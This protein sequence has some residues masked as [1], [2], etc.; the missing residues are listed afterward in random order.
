[1]IRVYV[2]IYT[3]KESCN[4]Y[5]T[6]SAERRKR[7]IRR[8]IRY[9]LSEL[10]VTFGIPVVQCPDAC[11]GVRFQP[12]PSATCRGRKTCWESHTILGRTLFHW[13]KWIAACQTCDTYY[14]ANGKEDWYC[15]YRCEISP[16][17]VC[18]QCCRPVCKK[19]RVVRQVV[20]GNRVVCKRGSADTFPYVTKHV[21]YHTQCDPFI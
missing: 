4:C 9:T 3:Q 21:Y 5:C 8:H 15:N 17:V 19:D 16:C 13:Y 7:I 18:T 14:V 10:E 12:C 6:M 1:M 2:Y 11:G 20:L